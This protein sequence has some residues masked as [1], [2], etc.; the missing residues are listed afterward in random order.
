MAHYYYCPFENSS[1][2]KIANTQYR[3]AVEYGDPAYA[4]YDPRIYRSKE[5]G[6][7]DSVV[8]KTNVRWETVVL[9]QVSKRR[10]AYIAIERTPPLSRIRP[11]TTL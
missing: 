7:T 4:N 2:P 5:A 1:D 11:P 9:N 3:Y 10:P 6:R 8:L